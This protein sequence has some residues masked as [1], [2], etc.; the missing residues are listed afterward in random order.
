MRSIAARLCAFALC[1]AAAAGARPA[2]AGD[3]GDAQDGDTFIAV[4]RRGGTRAAEPDALVAVERAAGNLAIVPRVQFNSSPESATLRL[5][6]VGI[7]AFSGAGPAPALMQYTVQVNMQGIVSRGWATYNQRFE[8]TVLYPSTVRE[9]LPVVVMLH[10]TQVI[11]LR[12]SG[13]MWRSC[14]YLATYNFMCVMTRE[15]PGEF[16]SSTS[17]SVGFGLGQRGLAMV[18][19]MYWLGGLYGDIIAGGGDVASEFPPSMLEE[20]AEDDVMFGGTTGD[21]FGVTPVVDIFDG[22]VALDAPGGVVSR[23]PLPPP[24]PNPLAGKVLQRAGVYGYSLGGLA[25]Q[26]TAAIGTEGDQ[27]RTIA[28]THAA[29]GTRATANLIDIPV[30]VATGTA[31]TITPANGP[32]SNWA[33]YDELPTPLAA[34]TISGACPGRRPKVAAAKSRRRC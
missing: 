20:P 9:P 26:V 2:V 19:N 7:N 5:E 34:V 31:D 18:R 14:S 28:L 29:R 30:L 6:P 10:P 23:D 4:D 1:A 16:G 21:L 17:L 8:M 22:D 12:T 15:S 25:T 24:P 32:A 11:P 33:L 13:D 3:A 27:I